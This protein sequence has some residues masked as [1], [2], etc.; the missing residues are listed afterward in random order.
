MGKAHICLFP[1]QI[2]L[3][4]KSGSNY[5]HTCGGSL[6]DSNWVMTAAHCVDRLNNSL[7]HEYPTLITI[8]M[9]FLGVT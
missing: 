3:Q 6:I 2:S 4:Y 8:L 7:R 9:S 5:Y 1:S